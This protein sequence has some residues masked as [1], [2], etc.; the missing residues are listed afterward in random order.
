MKKGYFAHIPKTAG[1][2]I[3]EVIPTENLIEI[4]R[5]AIL[6]TDANEETKQ[7]VASGWVKHFSLNYKYFHTLIPRH[8]FSEAFTFAF[9][10]NPFDR[11]VSSFCFQKQLLLNYYAECQNENKQ[12]VHDRK[13]H[14]DFAMVQSIADLRDMFDF[15][16]FLK[17]I[18]RC[19]DSGGYLAEDSHYV[20]QI[21]FT[22]KVHGNL[23]VKSLDFIGRF[24][25]LENDYL[26][27]CK[28]LEIAPKDLPHLKKGDRKHYREY[29]N[30]KTKRLVTELYKDDIIN[31]EY[32]F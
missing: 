29:Y 16:Y 8:E 18:M 7:A 19:F 22:H 15:E 9:I 24:E 30:D 4:N 23:F 27:V 13:H 12:F 28:F 14:P 21:Y 5:Y 10:R 26:K 1:S 32:K 3:R 20:P 11:I 31:F 6:N 17:Y 25:N 2:S